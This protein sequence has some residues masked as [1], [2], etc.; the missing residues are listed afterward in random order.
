M[1]FVLYSVHTNLGSLYLP[2]KVTFYHHEIL[3]F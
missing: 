3:L 1:Y 2:L